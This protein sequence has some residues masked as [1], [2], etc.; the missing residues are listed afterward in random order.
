MKKIKQLITIVMLAVIAVACGSSTEEVVNV[1]PAF[2]ID[3]K[4]DAIAYKMAYLTKYKEGEFV[5][6]DSVVI[7]NGAFTFTGSVE[8]PNVQ[9]ILFDD[10]KERI[11]VFIDNSDIS[12]TGTGL[13]K[14]NV[15]ITGA[16]LNTQLDE[17]IGK[18]KVYEDRLKL[19]ADEYYAAEEIGDKALVEA[20]D[21][22]YEVEDSLKTLFVEEYI[23]ANLNSVI[24]PY[25][26]LRYMMNKDID[27]IEKLNSSFSKDIRK[28]EYVALIKD[29]ITL[30]KST[31]IGQPAPLFSMN[32]KDGN[33]VALESFKGSYVM[34]DFWASWCGPC[35][36][37]NPNVVAAYAK[38]HDKGFEIFGVSF[39][40]NKEKWLKAVE[41]DQ[42]TW[43][44]VS[45][46]KGWGNAAGKIYGVRGIPH[47]VLIDKEGVIVA[48]NL[49]GEELHSKL[50]EIFDKN[51]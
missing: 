13:Q 26:S 45:D 33:P 50:A 44:H 25:L 20:A 7:E 36:A 49:R 47:S 39:D 1:E 21:Y 27:V 24:A 38:Y 3:V 4:I 17:F 14:E 34:I 51:S 29:H 12:I 10:S 23:N 11:V 31:Q 18:V 15:T 43:A 9:Y 42:L 37:E 6:S 41:D 48:K 28:S 19:I 2:K 35:R 32:D 46:L 40:E 16:K 5:K 30:T 22:K 8:S